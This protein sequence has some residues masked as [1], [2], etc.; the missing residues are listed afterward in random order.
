MK[1][2][3]S[4]LP[5]AVDRATFGAELGRL[6]VRKRLGPED[7]AEL[8]TAYSDRPRRHHTRRSCA[9]RTS[10]STSGSRP[11]STET[12]PD[13]AAQRCSRMDANIVEYA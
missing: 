12:S 11:V 2:E 5:A 4:S 6:R 9:Q 10:A 8:V 7:V 13:T 3:P 1:D